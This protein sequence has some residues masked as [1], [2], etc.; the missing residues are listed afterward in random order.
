MAAREQGEV[1]RDDV[2]ML[3]VTGGGYARI[4]ADF[5]LVHA[6]PHAVID[7]RHFT[8][9]RIREVLKHLF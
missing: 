3:N 6:K 4:F 1:G 5:D 9:D 2:V 7:K 8:E